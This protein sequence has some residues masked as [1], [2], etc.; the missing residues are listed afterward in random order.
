MYEKSKDQTLSDEMF[1]NP[2]NEYR[3]APFWAWNHTLKK[4]DLLRHLDYFEQMGMGGFHI[5]SRTGLGTP[6]LGEEFLNCVKACAG[7]AKEKGMFTYL[8]DEDR[9]PSGSAGGQVTRNQNYC[10][11]WMVLA[12]SPDRINDKYSRLLAVYD[13]TLEQGYLKSYYRCT[14]ADDDVTAATADRWYLFRVLDTPAA[15]FNNSTYVD[16]LNPEAIQTF[17]NMTHEKYYAALGKE[18]GS[19][20]PSIFTDEPQFQHWKTLGFSEE[21]KEVVMPYTDRLPDRYLEEYGEDFFETVPELVWELSGSRISAARYRFHRL[22]S[23]MFSAAFAHTLGSWCDAHHI[24]LTGHL[25]GEATLEEQT[26]SIGEAMHSYHYFSLPGIDML[27]DRREY[28]TAKQAQSAAHQDGRAGI[29]CENYGA[30][31]WDFDFRHHKLSGDWQA[32]L[33]VTLRVPHLSWDSMQGEAKRD[34]PASIY[35]QSPWYREYHQLEDHFAR[36]NTAL[37]RGKAVVRIAV[38]HPIETFWLHFGPREQTDHFRRQLECQFEKI[39]EW[40]LFSQLD[41]DF[42][43]ESLLGEQYTESE[44]G[45]FH[46]GQMHYDVVVVPGCETLRDTT[47]R[48][49]EIFEKNGGDVLFLGEAPGFVNGMTSDRGKQLWNESRHIC[50]QKRELLEALQPYRELSLRQ[51]DGTL[52]D[53]YLYQ[54]RQD[55]GCRWLFIANGRDPGITDVPEKRILTIVVQGKWRVQEYDT[56]GGTIRDLKTSLKNWKTTLRHT[57]YEHT[58][59]LLKLTP[60]SG[61]SGGMHSKNGKVLD[62]SGNTREFEKEEGIRLNRISDYRLEE[63]NVLLLDQAAYRLDQGEWKARD[64]ILRIDSR[65]RKYLGYPLRNGGIAQPWTYTP[66]PAEHQLEL[67]FEIQSE[68]SVPESFLAVEEPETMDI[69]LNGEKVTAVPQGC[70]VDECIRKVRLPQICEGKNQLVLKKRYGENSNLEWCYL[71]GNFGVR[72]NGSRSCLIK[73]PEEVGFGDYGRQGF[74]FYSGNFVYGIQAD[75]PAD[76]EYVIA[77]EKFRAPLLKVEV[78]GRT[79]GFIMISPYRVNLGF[80]NKGFHRIELTAY[81]NRVNAFGTIHQC[82]EN[83][84][85]MTP[86]AWRTQGADYSYEYQLRRCGI[87]AAPRLLKTNEKSE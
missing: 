10:K 20:I 79:A 77:A 39:T 70:Y 33:G 41:F 18:F 7:R 56:L 64:E 4:E 15:W 67:R 69:Y 53:Q 30:T 49:L 6:Y 66:E 31:N 40:L 75:I 62:K 73:I 65:C 27:R 12:P 14:D 63:P 25:L 59:I 54:L 45:K 5:H 68:I 36:I 37:T 9:W 3:G 23:D 43:A 34:Y 76:G 52:S 51:E 42:V 71:L 11:R 2:T 19:S 81:G 26:K 28:T 22:V 47:L 13:V 83:D 44:D 55:D 17:V 48:A 50:F 16:T 58:S 74:P 60:V 84:V 87:L 24:L 57:V 32:A 61:N 21:Q 72:V 35:Y 86:E 82:Q 8:Y 85:C 78:D 1:Q 29:A 80:L 38:I 46:I